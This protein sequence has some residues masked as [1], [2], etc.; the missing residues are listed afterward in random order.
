M[1]AKPAIQSVAFSWLPAKNGAKWG[2]LY[3]KGEWFGGELHFFKGLF[4]IPAFWIDAA[5]PFVYVC[6]LYNFR[7][8]DLVYVSVDFRCD[9]PSWS[10]WKALIL[11]VCRQT[12]MKAHRMLNHMPL[13]SDTGVLVE[14]SFVHFRRYQIPVNCE[15]DTHFSSRL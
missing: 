13:E 15:V 3:E 4:L 9:S 12:C 11:G 2:L 1:P 7:G 6:N 8:A 10:S 14:G 5:M